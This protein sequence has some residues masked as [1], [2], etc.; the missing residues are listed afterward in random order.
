[1]GN[2]TP[3]FALVVKGTSKIH[4]RAESPVK[5]GGPSGVPGFGGMGR[6]DKPGNPA[7]P[8]DPLVKKPD[9]KL[10]PKAIWQDALARG[11]A[12]P[13]II[14]AVADHLAMNLEWLHAAEFLKANL[15]QGIVVKPWVY[16][17]LAIA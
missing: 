7:R 3:A 17:S 1:M 10:D 6:L 11:G 8:G 15:R 2:Y 12:E 9:P 14:I 4:T 5:I 16:E 13:G